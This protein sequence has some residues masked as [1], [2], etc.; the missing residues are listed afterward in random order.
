MRAT[1]LRRRL[2]DA[3][4]PEEHEARERGWRVVRA[5]YAERRPS[6]A[7]ASAPRRLAIALAGAAIVLAVVLTPAGAKVVDFVRDV[8]RPNAKEAKPLTSLPAPGSLL[9]ESQ[10]GP[11]VFHRDGSQRLLGDYRQATWSPNGVFVAATSAHQLTAV[12]P[13]TGTVHWSING[14]HPTDPRWA[15]GNGYRVAYRSGS[16][17]RV[18][19]GDGTHDHLLDANV[20]PAPPAWRPATNCPPTSASGPCVLALAKPDGAV[21]MVDADSGKVLWASAAGPVPRLLD[22]SAHSSLV[23]ALSAAEL[24][25]FSAADGSLIQTV[26]LPA[27]MEATDGAFAPAGKSFA[28]TGTTRHGRSKALLIP[29]AAARAQPRSL[30]TD[31]GAFTD[32]TWSPDGH[33]LLIAWRKAGAWLF[34]NPEHPGHIKTAGQIS[35][36]FSPGTTAPA[37]FPR[38]AG[39]CCTQA[40]TG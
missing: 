23:A 8:V 5:A 30:L 32:V 28:V 9:V 17:M 11:W 40:G 21:R 6:T 20:A 39:W 3:P 36:Q 38:P 7:R 14:R 2:R 15:P 31:P 4:I 19:A 10:Q 1:E 25:V 22:W 34:L 12:E 37:G 24:R 26:R 13:D 18:V 35:R 16:S 33:W 27:G 29:L